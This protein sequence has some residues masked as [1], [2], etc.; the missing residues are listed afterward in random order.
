MGYQNFFATKLYTDIGASDATITLE[1][2]PAATSGRLVLEARNA[3][4]REV[5]KYTNVSGNQITGVTRGLGGTSAKS[6][7][8]N[9]LVEMNLTSEDIQDLYDAFNSFTPSGNAWLVSPYTFNTVSYLGNGSYQCVINGQNLT[10]IWSPGMRIRTT[11]AVAGM[12]QSMSFVRA[13]NQYAAKTG[14]VTG[15]TFTGNHT[16]EANVYLNNYP[17]SGQYANILTRITGNTGYGFRIN[18]T[19]QL[20]FFYASGTGF[21]TFNTYQTIPLRKQVHLAG[22]V[23]DVVSKFAIAMIGGVSVP[24]VSSSTAAS[25]VS[26]TGTSLSVGGRVDNGVYVADS[27]WDGYIS[28]VRVWSTA[29]TVSQVQ[30]NST[31]RLVGTE[32][33]LVHYFRGDGDWVDKVNSANNLTAANGA[34]FT[35]LFAPWGTQGDG[36]ISPNYDYGIIQR[37]V[38]SGGNSTVIV[39]VPEGCAIPTTAGGVSGVA[40]SNVKAP[41]GFPGQE[42][43]WTLETLIKAQTS[44]AGTAGTWASNNVKITLPIGSWGLGY[45][46]YT[47]IA[48]AGAT[49]LWVAMTLSPS[50][51]LETDTRLTANG[52][53]DNLSKTQNGNNASRYIPVSVGAATDYNLILLPSHSTSTLYWSAA[54]ISA[55]NSLL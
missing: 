43:K 12:T 47:Q 44:A 27:S 22:I 19:G 25:S 17:A 53:Q 3:T 2:P 51:T 11:R 14:G 40:Y 7:T 24:I 42:E 16:I 20:E 34:T 48:H 26:I 5:I 54:T 31:V 46:A 35:S 9:S 50:V 10:N 21:T 41:Y 55:K 18:S 6:H 36:S 33:N 28:E 45:Q 29:L 4:Q 1:T 32:P 39:Q 30:A 23:T 38:Y 13:S 15:G 37:V 8:K 52:V 49:F